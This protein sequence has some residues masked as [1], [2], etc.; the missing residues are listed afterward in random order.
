MASPQVIGSSMGGLR[1]ATGGVMFTPRDILKTSGGLRTPGSRASRGSFEYGRI[2]ERAPS[3][4]SSAPVGNA[5]LAPNP[6]L[7]II[8]VEQL[9]RE[10]VRQHY[11]DLKQACQ[12][13]D[14]DQS[15]AITKGELRRV[16]D[17]Y[18]QPLTR[19]QFDAMVAKVPA[20]ANGTINYCNFL[21]RFA[22]SGEGSRES[23]KMTSGHR[24]SYTKSPQDMGIDVL[25]RQLREK[26]GAYLK[27][28]L[29]GLQ[30]FDYNRDGKVQKHE[31]RKVIENYCFRMSD[32]QY[33]RLWSRYDFHHN[34]VVNYKEFL[35]RLGVNV[36]RHD[37]MFPES[38]KP[39]SFSERE[40][41]RAKQV[42]KLAIFNG[43]DDSVR[44][45]TFPQI[46]AELRRRLKENYVN[47][48]KMFMAFDARQDGFV[49]LEDLK[50]ILVQFTLPM[51][52]QLFAQLMDKFGLKASHK[53]PWEHFLEKFQNPRIEGNSQTIPIKPN[54]KVN[55]IRE[56]DREMEVE[57]ILTLL[58]KHVTN[59]YPSIKEAFLAF[60]QN[61]DGKVTRKE[62]RKILDKF[63]IRLKE[64][65][66]KGLVAKLDPNN[67]NNINYHAF[68][69][70][71]EVRET[72]EGHKWLDS[73]HRWNDRAPANLAWSTVEDI[74][75]EKIEEYWK[76][77]SSAFRLADPEGTGAIG[78]KSLKKIL[79]RHVLPVSDEHFDVLW[80]QC[81]ESPDGK[82]MFAEFLQKLGVDVS[83][84]DLVGPS[85]R[86][87]VLSDLSEQQRQADLDIRL[88]NVQLNA[89]ERTSQMSAD[90]VMVK[91]KDRMAQKSG[92][93]RENFLRYCKNR[94][95]KLYK[96]EFRE[97]LESF[98]MYMSDEQFGHLCE[99]IGFN[100]GPLTYSDFVEQFEDPRAGGPGEEIQRV[101]NH[102]YTELPL[103]N[104][105]AE[106]V[107]GQLMDKMR[108]AFG[109]LR[110]TFYKLDDN[111]DGLVEQD[112][113]RHLMD[114]LMFTI[115]EEEFK[116]LMSKLAINKRTKLSYR[117]FL[118]RFQVVD[119][120]GSHKWLDSDHRFNRT[121]DPIQLAADQVHDILVTKAQRQYQDLAKA[122]MSID[123]NGNGVIT[124]KELRDLLY[125]FMLPM[126]KEEFELLWKKY[127]VN[128]KGYI[129][130]QHFLRM[131]GKTFAPGD[132]AGVSRR[133]VEDSYEALEN[134]HINQM[135]KQMNI[136]VNQASNAT[137]ISASQ[138]EQALKDR[139]R[140]RYASFQTAFNELDLSK[141]GHITVKELKRVLLDHNYLVDDDTF[142]EFLQRIGVQSDKGKLS[143]IQFLD[144]FDE[145][146]ELRYRQKN[147]P[148]V[149]PES[150][151]LLNPD[152]AIKKL[153][154][155]M[156]TQL[157]ILKAAFGAF[158]K[159]K[160][161]R[162]TAPQLRRVLDNFCFKLT[163]KQFKHL[164]TKVRLHSDLTLSYLAFL[165]EFTTNE[166]EIAN[167]WFDSLNKVEE[168]TSRSPPLYT[169]EDLQRDLRETVSARFYRFAE[170][171]AEI[172]YAKI[173]VVCREDFKAVLDEIGFRMNPDQFESLWNTLP[174]NE[175]G[176]VEYRR[177]LKQYM[178][179]NLD[180][181]KFDSLSELP[182][183]TLVQPNRQIYTSPAA[184]TP[185]KMSGR[186]SSQSRLATP[187]VNAQ[188]VEQR[189]K[190]QIGKQWKDVQ[191]LCRQKDADNTG[192]VSAEDFKA[193]LESLGFSL[194]GDEFDQ[195]TTKY[196][197]KGNGKFAYLDFL[198]HFVLKL[199]PVAE[200]GD[201]TLM[202]RQRIHP[203]K[204]PTKPGSSSSDMIE[205]MLRVRQC[206]L[207]NWKQMRRVFRGM[208]PS[209]TGIVTASDFRSVLRQFNI[210][211][212]E[213]EFFHLMTYY[214]RCLEGKI[215]YNDFLRAFL[216]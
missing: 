48:K 115:S 14:I 73:E 78:Y 179:D 130:H 184:R 195:L 25:E 18:C 208:D 92:R 203:S 101:P 161:G 117:D 215:S 27:N 33:D 140:D 52:D 165:E 146:R 58:H 80:S 129:D 35:Q 99:V 85:T 24:Y 127:D 112:D 94:R 7:S 111:H 47:L 19:E 183:A 11:H 185:S 100:R 75:R 119:A 106:E 49:S 71:F 118:E 53:I 45:M 147:P 109:S 188:G 189:L 134:H 142:A 8:E 110:T 20:N 30:L 32:E 123:K 1:P 63:T 167:N 37:A 154:R 190:S 191:R 193:I 114:A 187:L 170:R 132:D 50:S 202:S 135:D 212:S 133:I 72:K 216:Q 153:K 157:P 57:E 206:I 164:M 108:Q 207:D 196:D 150:F 90:E 36:K 88:T 116:R 16:L 61:R 175:F 143:Y 15:L 22:S 213:D 103:Y 86:I 151:S 176:N 171:F 21:D 60:D 128:N 139:F 198:K 201:R 89:L 125:T 168:E 209:G 64:Q 124:K 141:T 194:F 65:Q 126:T 83:P 131:M 199:Q 87:Q 181:S 5:V 122:F 102:R 149:R 204:I 180:V 172:D 97:V 96:K 74:L 162:I 95:G 38:T 177:F 174:I 166:D 31:L 70:L 3:R 178:V 137:F 51:S 182:R 13:Y 2:E 148:V 62:L 152:K 105:T 120:P 23:W 200:E 169:L 59:M 43:S 12:N 34:G 44:G 113:F 67:E 10:K 104:M 79:N 76:S 107:E 41:N 6:Q 192:E 159:G 17:I 144:A 77:I 197:L 26:V 9:I 160:S 186:L 136:T 93:I 173:G 205:A 42:E 145:A 29:K 158:D 46:E 210:N 54:H 4:A 155:M 68:L 82:I 138:L 91:L 39:V 84:G 56:G 214:D 211:L 55:P 69:D 156:A 121:L 66:F 28:F 81:E 40:Q 98:G 163:D